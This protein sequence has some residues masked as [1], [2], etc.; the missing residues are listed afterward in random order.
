MRD[1]LE[2]ADESQKE[3]RLAMIRKALKDKAPLTFS[4][5]ET[6]GQLQSF[7]E[8]RDA[9]MMAYFREAQNKVWEETMATF[10]D[11]FDPSYD[12]TSSPM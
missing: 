6:S 11:F 4:E 5:L 9:K 1:M 7:L 3:N 12:E 2:I 8:A 10:L